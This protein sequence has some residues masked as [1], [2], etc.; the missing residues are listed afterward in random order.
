MKQLITL[1]LLTFISSFCLAQN[2]TLI[3]T[4]P[5]KSVKGEKSSASFFVEIMEETF[6]RSGLALRTE[7]GHW[8]ANQKKVISASPS[9][10]FVITP[11]TRTKER[12]D[13][14]DWI[15][16]ITNYKLQFITNDKSI[17][18]TNLED[19]KTQPVCAY[20]ESPAEYQLRDLGFTKIRTKVQEQKCFQGLKKQTTKVM[21][22]HGKLAA[23]QG[24]KLIGGNPE[25]LIY[26]RSF[27]EEILYLASTKGAV[28][29]EDKKKLADAFDAMKIDGT[30]KRIFD[31]Y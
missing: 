20:R 5:S 13:A 22:A 10:G 1:C 25:Q 6:I 4:L 15:L 9:K 18:I 3:T 30:Y 11:L 21:L 16:P 29:P 19:L 8:I 7:K 2:Y 23:I 14:Y 28:S 31:T 27:A 17:D 12:E 26:G 24:Y